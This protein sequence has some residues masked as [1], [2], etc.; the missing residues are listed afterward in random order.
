MLLQ[1]CFALKRWDGAGA[2]RKA[3]Q[4]AG[5]GGSS[6]TCTGF[7]FESRPLAAAHSTYR[8]GLHSG[9]DS[10]VPPGGWPSRGAGHGP[11][12]GPLR[13]PEPLPPAFRR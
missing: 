5:D 1:G 12:P 11:G 13:V 2:L 9:P 4:L 7:T 6:L 3:A 8:A 10:L